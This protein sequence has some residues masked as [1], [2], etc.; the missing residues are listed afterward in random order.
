MFVYDMGAMRTTG[1][2][3]GIV[4]ASKEIRNIPAGATIEP[5]ASA[6]YPGD[7]LPV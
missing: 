1:K 5:L 4:G 2:A 7:V 6:V 3:W